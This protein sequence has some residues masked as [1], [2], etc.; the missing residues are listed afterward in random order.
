MQESDNEGE[1]C[2]YGVLFSCLSEC[3]HKSKSEYSCIYTI[4]LFSMVWII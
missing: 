4:H 2:A 3:A 1:T